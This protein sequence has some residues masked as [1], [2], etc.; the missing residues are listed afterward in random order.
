MGFVGFFL[1]FSFFK[2]FFDAEDFKIQL[3]HKILFF[4]F[5]H[6]VSILKY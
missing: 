1:F 4:F 5:P 3:K 6:I 2:F